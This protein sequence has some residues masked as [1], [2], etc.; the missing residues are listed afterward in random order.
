ML[1]TFIPIRT[2]AFMYALLLPHLVVLRTET[3]TV[4]L[5]R[6]AGEIML[7]LSDEQLVSVGF[8]RRCPFL[9]ACCSSHSPCDL[10]NM[11]STRQLP[12][13]P[14]IQS[15]CN[16]LSWELLATGPA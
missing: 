8:L 11:N 4:C 12:V 9:T 16:W 5:R 3:S 15:N 13:I 6:C 7:L 14:L 2:S 10:H 1:C